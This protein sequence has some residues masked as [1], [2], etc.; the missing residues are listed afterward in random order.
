MTQKLNNKK[1]KIYEV[2]WNEVLKLINACSLK[3]SF[4]NAFS[5]LFC[6]DCV[7]IVCD[8]LAS[9]ARGLMTQHI[10]VSTPF[11]YNLRTHPLRSLCKLCSHCKRP[12]WLDYKCRGIVINKGDS[13]WVC[14]SVCLGLS[15]RYKSGGSGKF[16]L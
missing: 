6:Y 5:L 14:R 10:A 8:E 4:E 13:N 9:F 7:N 16:Y 11:P 3:I 1:A 15:V 12:I 2:I